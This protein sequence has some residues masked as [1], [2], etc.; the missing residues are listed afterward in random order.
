MKRVNLG[1]GGVICGDEARTK[2]LQTNFLI[3]K[4]FFFLFV[5]FFLLVVVERER[6][7]IILFF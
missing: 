5:L 6:I 2:G 7:E 1:N 3:L 4:F